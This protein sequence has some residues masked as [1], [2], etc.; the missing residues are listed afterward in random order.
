MV[1]RPVSVKHKVAEG[2]AFTAKDKADNNFNF[3]EKFIFYEREVVIF[4]IF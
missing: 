2:K 4:I 1:L 3:F